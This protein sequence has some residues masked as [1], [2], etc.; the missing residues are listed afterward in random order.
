[1]GRRFNQSWRLETCPSA[2]ISIPHA[3]ISAAARLGSF[4]STAC[5]AADLRSP[6]ASNQSSSDDAARYILQRRA[7]AL[8]QNVL[9]RGVGRYSTLAAA[10]LPASAS[11]APHTHRARRRCWPCHRVRTT[12]LVAVGVERAPDR[13]PDMHPVIIEPATLPRNIWR[14]PYLET[15]PGRA[16]ALCESRLRTASQ[17]ILTPAGHPAVCR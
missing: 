8:T 17:H 2:I 3:A 13:G 11:G 16:R 15:P 14:R 6:A 5:S 7:E 9:S 10:A 4:P 12:D 1:M